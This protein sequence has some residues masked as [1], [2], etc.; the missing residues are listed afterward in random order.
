MYYSFVVLLL[1]VWTPGCIPSRLGHRK[2]IYSMDKIKESVDTSKFA[3][4]DS[5]EFS[6]VVFQQIFI[7]ND[8]PKFL[9][10]DDGIPVKVLIKQLRHISGTIS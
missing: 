6:W 2:V 4:E 7:L 9:I 8:L 1:D 3:K 10:I 5:Q